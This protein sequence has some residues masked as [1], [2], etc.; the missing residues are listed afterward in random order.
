M[1]RISSD[2]EFLDNCVD[3]LWE[4]VCT[5]EGKIKDISQTSCESSTLIPSSETG[6]VD[7]SVNYIDDMINDLKRQI[8]A[9]KILGL[10]YQ[11]LDGLLKDITGDIPNANDSDDMII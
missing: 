2:S 1:T 3:S 11:D 6:M 4:T 8:K 9:I 5:L 7:S 10:S